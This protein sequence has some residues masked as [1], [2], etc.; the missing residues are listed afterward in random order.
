MQG[1]GTGRQRCGS[2]LLAVAAGGHARERVDGPLHGPVGRLLRAG[3]G[4]QGVEVAGQVAGLRGQEQLIGGVPHPDGQ[5]RTDWQGFLLPRR[6]VLRC[7]SKLGTQVLGH[8]VQLPGR[9]GPG[10]R[11]AGQQRLQAGL[12]GLHHG[13]PQFI[14]GQLGGAFRQARVLHAQVR[15]V[16]VQAQRFR[17]AVPQW[18]HEPDLQCVPLIGAQGVGALRVR[19]GA[20]FALARLR[21]HLHA[22]DALTVQGAEDPAPQER[23]P[24]GADVQPRDQG[25][26]VQPRR[27]ALPDRGAQRAGQG[28]QVAARHQRNVGHGRG[29]RPESG[30][31][32]KRGVPL[33]ARAGRDE[34]DREGRAAGQQVAQPRRRR[35]RAGP[36][37]VQVDQVRPARPEQQRRHPPGVRAGQRDVQQRCRIRSGAQHALERQ[38]Q[39]LGQ[40]R[41]QRAG[42]GQEAAGHTDSA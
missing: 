5:P 31:R 25:G 18:R 3:R 24:G 39:L 16:R 10:L 27:A 40:R 41:V 1:G 19:G 14:L 21:P 37:T 11:V 4:V 12:H 17:G 34:R 29:V 9:V 32:Q 30:V 36:V 15:A 33:R 42:P 35:K 28:V 2:P 23:Q 7:Q 8:G 13:G 26:R 6:D 20:Q 22:G 38:G